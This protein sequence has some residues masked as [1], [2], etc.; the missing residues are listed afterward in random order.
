MSGVKGMS[1]GR[2]PGAGRKPTTALE[3]DVMGYPGRRGR[4][5]AHPS[6]GPPPVVAPIAVC[7]PP[8]DLPPPARAV[9]LELAP[10]AA[11]ARTLT[12]GTALAFGVLCRNVVLERTLAGIPLEQGGS[13]HR[14]LIMR[15][16]AELLRFNLSPCGKAIYQAEPVA[17]PA[18]PLAKFLTR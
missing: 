14:G 13:N 6:A 3:R 9:W 4:V 18:N 16:D 5:L 11:A 10:H 7:A 8:D 2:R 12:P 1:G 17:P 15:V